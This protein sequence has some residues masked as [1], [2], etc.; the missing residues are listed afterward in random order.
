[1]QV[2]P[3]YL[4]DGL[5]RRGLP[6]TAAQAF[7]MNFKDESGLNSGINEIE[8]LV[9][10]SRG[11]FGLYQLTG[12][13]RVAYEQFAQQR[14]V[15]LA[16]PDAQMDFL[17]MEL[18][19]PESRAAKSILSAPDVNT[20]AI[21]IARDFLRPA[22]ENLAKRV[23]RYGGAEPPSYGG[24]GNALAVPQGQPPMGNAL[25]QQQ[26]PEPPK[27]KPGFIDP[28]MFMTETNAL[29]PAPLQRVTQN[30]LRR[31]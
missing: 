4:V 9:P 28:E 7:V 24:Q 14:G 3:G 25:A 11:G 2:D 15:N 26:E 8:P 10:G 21:A 16:D 23:A 31:V 20:A 17:M 19:G 27:F 22:P 29:A 30:S 1:M 12:P 18:Q 6:P 13:R 5:T